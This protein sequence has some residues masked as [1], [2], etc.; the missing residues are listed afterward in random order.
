MAEAR[1]ELGAALWR[2]ADLVRADERRRSFR[3]KAYRRAVWSLDDLS[4]DLSDPPETILSTPGIGAGVLRLII[5][6]EETGSLDLLDRLQQL[7]PTD[8][9]TMRRLPRMTPSILRLLKGELGVETTEQLRGA[10]ESGAVE[11]LRGV[12][13]GT[14]E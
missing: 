2:L 1:R 12:G 3:A 8:V 13:P 10:I 14:A 4:P 7:Y 11:A 5:E 6:F 9:S